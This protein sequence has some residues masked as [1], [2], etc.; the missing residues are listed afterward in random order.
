MMASTC[1]FVIVHQPILRTAPER[2]E[3]YARELGKRHSTAAM[4]P[5][6]ITA[7]GAQP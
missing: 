6:W 3:Q 4:V 2:G 1:A 7:K 5:V